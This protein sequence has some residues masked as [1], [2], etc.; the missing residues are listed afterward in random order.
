MN[1]ETVWE[2]VEIVRRGMVSLN[3]RVDGIYNELQQAKAESTAP[4]RVS[5][6]TP[7][8]LPP[9]GAFGVEYWVRS[10]GSRRWYAA[11]RWHSI[12]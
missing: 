11:G 1:L 6:D 2:A 8:A 3:K 5:V 9:R 4:V 7:S 10:D 12:V